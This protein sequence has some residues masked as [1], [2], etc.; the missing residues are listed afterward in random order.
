MFIK[1]L[2]SLLS[3]NYSLD[4]GFYWCT[5]V[6]APWIC[7]YRAGQTIAL[8]VAFDRFLAIAR[9]TFYAKRQGNVSLS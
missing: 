1:G 6:T 5:I 2:V 4:Y 3:I 8:L 7:G 9:P